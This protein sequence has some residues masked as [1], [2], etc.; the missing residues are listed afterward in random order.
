MPV[1]KLPARFA[2]AGYR[3]RAFLMSDATVH[4]VLGA[5]MVMRGVGMLPPPSLDVHPWEPLMSESSWAIV[6]ILVGVS[7][8]I[9]APWHAT[10]LAGF[11][12]SA[13]VMLTI[14]WG[15]TFVMVDV[16]EFVTR[17][18]VYLALGTLV[19][20]A[21]WRGKRGEVK[22][23]ERGVPHDNVRRRR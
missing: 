19:V 18:S 2:P 17:G 8:L 16:D 3:A 7:N 22:A 5:Y 4:L 10:R 12:M 9:V 14:L 11:V 23:G 6:W 1:D 20:W 15:T 21:V 13:G